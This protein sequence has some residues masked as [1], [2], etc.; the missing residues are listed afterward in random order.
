MTDEF[1]NKGK[2]GQKDAKKKL[3]W[4][5]I[6]CII[7]IGIEVAGGKISNS[8]SIW[9]DAAHMFADFSG[10]AI[11]M[12]AIWIAGIKASNSMSYGYH[13]AEIVGALISV[14]LIW[15]MTGVLVNEAIHRL[16]DGD[17]EIESFVMLIVAVVG[18]I[19]NIMMGQI[20]HS[21][22]GHHGHSHGGGGHG[23]SHGHSEKKKDTVKKNHGHS[24][25]DD[26]HGHSH[27]DNG[28]KS[29]N[30][31]K[32]KLIEKKGESHGHSHDK[33]GDHGHSHDEGDHGHSHEKKKEKHG[34]SHDEG[35]HGHSHDDDD[36]G[37]SHGKDD[38]G[39]A[40]GSDS[41]NMDGIDD[42]V[43]AEEENVNIRAAFIHVLGDLIQSVGIV[44]AAIL[45]YIFPEWKW[46]D[47]ICTFVF[48]I[49]VL[50]TT[51]PIMYNLIRVLCEG[52]PMGL[53]VDKIT[54]DLKKVQGAVDIHDIHVWSL[55]VGKSAM[56]AHLT[57]TTPMV[58]LRKA[59]RLMKKKY[60]IFHTT[61]Q[62]EQSGTKYQCKSDLH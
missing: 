9:N 33:G 5:S 59:T 2:E 61:I 6:V 38:H 49:L 35:D 52:T 58:T 7:F 1:L 22:G 8:L 48:C 44:I 51:F 4:V 12:S 41:E 14:L 20:L 62:V 47:P 31:L 16:I 54:A 50:F 29:S 13:R 28:K 46:I 34:H 53:N 17:Y 23:H 11:S 45:I 37:H 21:A 19:C 57:S 39:H 42:D 10:F 60:K 3:L 40:S 56:S 18:L 26:N 27:D 15:V 36:H 55:S 32:E 43:S 25:D 24:H 30:D